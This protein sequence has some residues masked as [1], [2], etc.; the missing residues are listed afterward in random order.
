MHLMICA[1]PDRTILP[2]GSQAADG[3]CRRF[4][5]L[6]ARPEEMPLDVTGRDR[7]PGNTDMEYA[8]G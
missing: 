6:A 7:Q 8:N 3:V 2:D 1:D 5:L 4:T